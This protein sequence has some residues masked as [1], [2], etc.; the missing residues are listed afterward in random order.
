MEKHCRTD[1]GYTGLKDVYQQNSQRDD[2]QQS[3][4]LA[5]TLKYLYLIF[6]ED[7]LL[8]LDKWVLNT[9]AHPLPVSGTNPASIE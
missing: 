5:E 6:S 2:V 4:F 7:S 8:P 3:F 1:G 9:E